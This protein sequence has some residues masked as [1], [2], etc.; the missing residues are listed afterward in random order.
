MQKMGPIVVCCGMPL[1]RMGRIVVSVRKM[2][3]MNVKI[4]E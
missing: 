4:R 2:K 3:A 1:K